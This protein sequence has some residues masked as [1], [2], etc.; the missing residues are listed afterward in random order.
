MIADATLERCH[1]W[2]NAGQSGSVAYFHRCCIGEALNLQSAGAVPRRGIGEARTSAQH[3]SIRGS[4]PGIG[5]FGEQPPYA[6]KQGQA[7]LQLDEV[8]LG[9]AV[10]QVFRERRLDAEE[11][12]HVRLLPTLVDAG[13]GQASPSLQNGSR[14]D[15]FHPSMLRSGRPARQEPGNLKVNRA[16]NAPCIGGTQRR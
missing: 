6:A 14:S 16:L 9:A 4:S 10:D 2:V 12:G 15:V 11:G 13:D 3:E 5:N 1:S 7:T 8:R